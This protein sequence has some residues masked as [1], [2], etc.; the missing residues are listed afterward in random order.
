MFFCTLPFMFPVLRL[1]AVGFHKGKHVP[2][3]LFIIIIIVTCSVKSF[4]S[5]TV[6]KFSADICGSCQ[7]A[8][9]LNVSKCWPSSLE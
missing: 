4:K 8:L 3:E 6:L 2:R 9:V 1:H 7:D 5:V